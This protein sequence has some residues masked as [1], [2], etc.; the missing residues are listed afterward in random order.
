MTAE[1]TSATLEGVL[2]HLAKRLL[3]RRLYLLHTLAFG[4]RDKEEGEGES[5]VAA[6]AVQEER[7]GNVDGLDQVHEGLGH[8]EAAQEA[9][10]DDQALTHAAN[11]G[12][13]KLG[14][15]DPDQGAV[16]GARKE[17]RIYFYPTASF[18]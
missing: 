7:P 10:T 12:R 11:L 18:F 17:V 1:I 5:K 13:E 6:E 8:D 16:S 15:D 4:L 9:A 3:E 14:G 2:D